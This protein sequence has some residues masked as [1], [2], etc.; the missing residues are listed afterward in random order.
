MRAMILF[1]FIFLAPQTYDLER[2]AAKVKVAFEC[3][4]YIDL[5][6]KCENKNRWTFLLPITSCFLKLHSVFQFQ[7]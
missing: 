6:P 3:R 2:Q 7:M 1:L 5:S 4:S